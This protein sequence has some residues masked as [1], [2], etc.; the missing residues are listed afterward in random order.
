MKR[1]KI[2]LIGAGNVG[3]ACLY[4]AINNMIGDEYIL[5]DHFNEIGEGQSMELLD[6]NGVLPQCDAT[7]TNGAYNDC[8]VAV[9]IAITAGRPQYPDETSL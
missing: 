8:D 1:K 9:I 3:C 5:I 4:S 7:I 2:D 6:A